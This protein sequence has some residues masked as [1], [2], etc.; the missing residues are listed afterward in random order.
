MELQLTD[1][2]NAAF[3]VFIVLLTRVILTY[4][5]DFLK[6]ISKVDENIRRAQKNNA[7]RDEKFY[8][9]Q[10]IMTP[11]TPLCCAE[12][13]TKFV[14]KPPGARNRHDSHNNCGSIVDNNDNEVVANGH[15]GTNGKCSPPVQNGVST[16]GNGAH[17][18]GTANGD[19]HYN[20]V[21]GRDYMVP[22]RNAAVVREMTLDTIMNGKRG[23]FPGLI[24]LIKK[25]LDSVEIDLQVSC[26]I[27]EYLNLISKRA[28]G[29]YLT[30][31]QW[32]RDFVRSHPDYK[33]DSVVN[34]RIVY[35]LLM[36]ADKIESGEM[37]C[38]ELFAKPRHRTDRYY[39]SSS[40]PQR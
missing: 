36:T 37:D 7:V 32:M 2:E 21:S 39:S 35:D 25:Y 26:S 13:Y 29:E 5:L 31:A 24:P 18:N 23:E 10:N 33:F 30:T 1:F 6:P 16:N 14:P 12:L 11:G 34:D 40:S 9:R 28:S 15:N 20:D 19:S 17:E 38:P 3:A 22:K 8:F 4:K 27:M